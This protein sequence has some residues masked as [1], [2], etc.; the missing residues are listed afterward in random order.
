MQ[1]GS[2]H[3]PARQAALA[4]VAALALALSACGGPDDEGGGGGGGAATAGGEFSSYIG[5]PENP[6]IPGD[7][8]ETEGG[9]VVDSLWT[10]LVQYDN[11][12]NE[13]EFTGVAE[14]IESD[15]QQTW[16][17]T[18]KDGWTFHDGTP[19]N[20]QSFVDAWNWNAYG[21]NG[22]GN[23][24]FFANIDGYDAMQGE[25]ETDDDG[26]VTK[27]VKE[28]EAKE[29]SGLKVVDDLTFTVKLSEPFSIFPTTLGYTAFFPLP[30]A[31][32]DD[33]KA[34]GKQPIGNGPWMANE[35]FEPGVGITLDKYKDYAGEDK[36]KADRV[37]LRVYA[38]ANTGYTD[39]QAGNLDISDTLPQSALSSGPD[40]FGDRWVEGPRG[41]MTPLAFPLYDK[42]FADV[43]V[44]QA[45]SMAI[46]RDA[47][48]KSIFL[49]SRLPAHSFASPVVEGYNENACAE[50]TEFNPEKAKALLK[51]SGFDTSKPISLWFNSGAGHEEW[52]EAVG[53]QLKENLGIVDYKLESLDFAEYLPLRDAKKITG[54]YR[55]GWIMDY[56][57]IQNFLAP[58]FA[59]A[60]Q[61]PAGSNDTYY[62][63]KEFDALLSKGNSADTPEDAIAAYQE[64]EQILC[65][66]M[67]QAP[68]FYGKNQLVH[69]EKVDNVVFN[70]FGRIE[71]AQ[72]TVTQ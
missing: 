26:N 57:H 19:V 40:E 63:N 48:T 67:P 7:T 20:A 60:A 44:R 34:F 38:D 5:E 65:E 70:A 24:Y 1:E 18:L 53:N 9:Q 12:T 47:I 6:L 17:I 25:V 23:S 64:A 32:F 27:V 69:S 2:M 46:D 21:P 43:R 58:I 15:D 59:E 14:S 66:D 11:K 45:F 50:T 56:P 71:L 55:A 16:T 36:A 52:M 72:V 61:P 4:A 68:L 41:D 35:P 37:E 28:P 29:L 13:P 3:I 31:F 22:A 39:V 51:E 30:K 42:R 33:P 54:P 10:G 49:G 8:N 62:A